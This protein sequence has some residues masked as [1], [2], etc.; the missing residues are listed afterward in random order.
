MKHP[1][2]LD[3]PANIRQLWRGFLAVL[4]LTLVAGFFVDPHPHFAI[5]EWFGFHAAYGFISCVLMIISAKFMGVF[6]KR[7]DSHYSKDQRDE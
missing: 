2:W 3:D 6:L 7:P 1:H 5:E 4:A